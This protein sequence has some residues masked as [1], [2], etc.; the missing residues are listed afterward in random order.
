MFAIDL[1]ASRYWSA[2]DTAIAF[3][4]KASSQLSRGAIAGIMIGILTAVALI[5]TSAF[6]L[7]CKVRQFAVENSNPH[8]DRMSPIALHCG[9]SRTASTSHPLHAIPSS[10]PHTITTGPTSPTLASPAVGASEKLSSPSTLL[11]DSS[12][13]AT[14]MMG[15]G[16]GNA[17][18]PGFVGG[19]YTE[20]DD[21]QVIELNRHHRNSF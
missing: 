9:P 3:D 1:H 21:N 18:S 15:R 17:R 2:W 19:K 20:L 4:V 10:N 8:H 11:H 12:G 13:P 6:L 16:Y 5:A 7:G 14:Y